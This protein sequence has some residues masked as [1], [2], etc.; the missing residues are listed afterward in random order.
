MTRTEDGFCWGTVFYSAARED[1]KR[2][3]G[4]ASKRSGAT[5]D[6]DLMRRVSM[7]RQGGLVIAA[8]PNSLFEGHLVIY[9]EQKREDLS[10]DDLDDMSAL[11]P[12]HPGFTFIHNIV[13]RLD[14]RL[15]SLS[16]YLLMLPSRASLWR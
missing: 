14:R 2:R 1:Y 10:F 15:G 11:A 9:P 5:F 16:V 3:V 13:R 12:S 7:G 4:D 6:L 8:N